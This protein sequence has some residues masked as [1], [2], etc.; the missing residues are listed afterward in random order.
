MAALP[1]I[2]PDPIERELANQYAR[3]QGQRRLPSL[4][5][6]RRE[7]KAVDEDRYQLTLPE[8]GVTLEIDRLRREHNELIG[9]LSARCELPGAYTV[10]GSLS[11]AD[12][13]LSSARARQERAKLL[14]TRAN[15][16]DQIDWNGLLEE[17]CQR[18]LQA[19]RGGQ[20]AVDLR[21]L[22]EPKTDEV[23]EVEGLPLLRRH[24]TILFGDGGS[25][26]SYLSLYIA[27][28]LAEHGLSV[29]V[30]DWE[31]AGDDHRVRLQRLFPDGMPRV[32]YA[33][34]ERPLVH[35]VDRL[36]RIV[37]ENGIDFAVFDSVAFACDGPP[38]A[39]E[40]AGRYF[41]AV[42]QIG[43]GSLHIAHVNKGENADQKPFGSA[44]WHNGARATW[45]VKLAGGS[46]DGDVLNLGLFN[47]KT[48]LGRLRP[49]LGYTLTFTEECTSFRRSEV[50]DNP[51]L[52]G[53]LSVRQ[54]MAHLLRKGALS[55]EAIAE[56]I[57][58]EVET[59]KRTVRRYKRQFTVIDGGRVGLLAGG[60][61]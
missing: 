4:G 55:P 8:I 41:R 10:N 52:A 61:I 47:R 9:E 56:E 51:D 40:V 7:F 33:R 1:N 34:C 42:R 54:R 48:N 3:S 20:P 44:F 28:K 45:Y 32:M 31:L 15:T 57:E 19:D 36:R 25:C 23:I 49:P 26:K 12:L 22:P 18:V 39:A 16:R 14:A 2:E 43:N 35:E 60:G 24:P 27:G 46:S 13:N 58:A 59:V 53:Q 11:I 30:F 38:E 6:I 50:A 5:L 29:G 21:L 17:F 37:R